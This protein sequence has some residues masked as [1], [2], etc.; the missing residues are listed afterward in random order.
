MAIKK[1]IKFKPRLTKH[2]T[3]ADRMGLVQSY[4]TQ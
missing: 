3:F 1:K 2:L 4:F